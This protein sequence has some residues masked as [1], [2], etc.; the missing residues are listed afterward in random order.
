MA[1]WLLVNK[2]AQ[3]GVIEGSLFFS[4]SRAFIFL[5]FCHC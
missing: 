1:L 4:F 5:N 3:P 2:K